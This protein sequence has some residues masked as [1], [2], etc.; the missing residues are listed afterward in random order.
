L[1][2]FIRTTLESGKKRLIY[3][4]EIAFVT[5]TDNPNVVDIQLVSGPNFGVI[6]EIDAVSKTLEMIR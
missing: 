1:T 2:R 4:D 3:V 6:G 5:E